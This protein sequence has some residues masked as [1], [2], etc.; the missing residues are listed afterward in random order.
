MS[1]LRTALEKLGER[2][3][4]DFAPRRSSAPPAAARIVA[5]TTLVAE[6]LGPAAELV[7]PS[8]TAP[9]SVFAAAAE[10]PVGTTPVVAARHPAWQEAAGKVAGLFPAPAILTLVGCGLRRHG[11]TDAELLARALAAESPA[12][13]EWLDDACWQDA[14]LFARARRSVLRRGVLAAAYLSAE[15]AVKRHALLAQLNGVLLLVESGATETRSADVVA[16]TLRMQGAG[17][18][19]ALLLA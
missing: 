16:T 11:A 19:G 6:A 5:A 3:G 4:L 2:G 7:A 9:P 1:A 15:A 10:A 8:R 13:V 17:V 18:R 12:G 14:E